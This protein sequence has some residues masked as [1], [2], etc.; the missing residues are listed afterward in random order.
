MGILKKHRVPCW[1]YICGAFHTCLVLF[2][3]FIVKDGLS[4]NEGE[5]GMIWLCFYYIDFPL[6]MAAYPISYV[7]DCL[8]GRQVRLADEN[9]FLG[10]VF[11]ILGGIQWFCIP[12]LISS[13]SRWVKEHIKQRRRIRHLC[14]TCCYNLTGNESGVCPECGTP[15]V[16][17][18]KSAG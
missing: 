9:L 18:E 3:Y 16:E 5:V 14:V 7:F 17:D 10:I 13:L 2:C 1:S 8:F 12:W 6:G 15:I 4:R 11:G